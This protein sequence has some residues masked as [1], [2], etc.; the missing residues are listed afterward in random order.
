MSDINCEA[1]PGFGNRR[2]ELPPLILH[3]FADS[4]GP[5]QVMEASRAALMLEG[6]LS[7]GDWDCDELTR[8]ILLGRFQEIRMLYFV[9]KD[10][11]RWMDQCVEFA[12]REQALAPIKLNEQSFA[13]LLTADVPESADRKLKSWGVADYKGVFSRAIGL[14]SVFAEP[15][16]IQQLSPIFL[17]HYGQYADHLFTCWQ[18][19]ATSQRASMRMFHFELYASAEYSRLLESRWAD[20]SARE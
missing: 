1:A 5:E 12:G 13:L 17:R 14:N 2:W 11:F 18:Q 7:S 20:D 19:L 10:L 4:S 15:P 16:E 3:P 8:R 9:G 6:L